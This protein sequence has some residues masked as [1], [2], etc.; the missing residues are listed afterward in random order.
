MLYAVHRHSVLYGN[1]NIFSISRIN[2][3]SDQNSIWSG[4]HGLH[5]TA[6]PANAVVGRG[7]HGARSIVFQLSLAGED[8]C[9]HRLIQSLLQPLG[10][11]ES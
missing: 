10:T 4:S 3:S 5:K 7:K 1:V 8:W 2:P 9:W 11:S 6:P